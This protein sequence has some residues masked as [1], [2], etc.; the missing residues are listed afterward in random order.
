MAKLN[1]N[2]SEAGQRFMVEF[3][4]KYPT[5]DT[6]D[7][8]SII[9]LVNGPDNFYYGGVYKQFPEYISI[10]TK[11]DFSCYYFYKIGEI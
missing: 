1:N 6:E 5:V 4:K 11:Y 10:V 7:L 8:D 3:H 2:L 9:P